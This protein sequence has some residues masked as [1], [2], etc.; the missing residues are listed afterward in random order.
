MINK[1]IIIGLVIAILFGC[2]KED[3]V[4]TTDVYSCQSNIDNIHPKAKKYQSFIEEKVAQGLPGISMLIETPEGIWTGAAGVADIPNDIAMR[5]CNLHKVGSITKS[6]TATLILKLYEKEELNL[7]DTVSQYLND[8]IV[9]KVA[10]TREATI[11]QLLNHTSGI[12]DYLSQIPY[13]VA[14]LNDPVYKW[15]VQE[16]LEYVF[17]IDSLYKP[18]SLVSYSN[19]NY[20]LL[21]MIVE[22]ITGKSGT[23]LYKEMIF[24]PL[25]MMDT[26]FN[27]NGEIPSNLVRGYYEENGKGDFVDITTHSFANHSMVGGVSSTVED[28]NKYLKAMLVD[29]SIFPNRILDKMLYI[30]DTPFKKPED[31]EYGNEYNVKSVAGFGLGWIKMKSMHGDVIGHNGGYNGRRARMWFFPYAQSSIVYFIN[32]SGESIETITKELHRNEMV[33]LISL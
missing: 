11:R 6:F 2:T 18:G 4:I 14:Y 10:N 8:I 32:A 24:D 29:K 5:S 15:T 16:E 23:Q 20:L 33:D 25:G 21:G 27:Q 30:D 1:Y 12:P 28:L 26:H 9:E 17:N 3:P 22:K 7:D 31:F 13:Y 19:T